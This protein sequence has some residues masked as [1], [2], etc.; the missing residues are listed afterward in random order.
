MHNLDISK[1]KFAQFVTGLQDLITNE[2]KKYDPELKITE[3]I[4]QRTDHLGLD[5]GGGR[6]RYHQGKI[7][8]A[9]GVNT[10]KVYGAIDPKFSQTLHGTG[11][12]LWATGISLIIHPINPRIPTVHANF[13][14]IHQGDKVWFGGGADLTPF[15]PYPE[16][17]E[18]FHSVWKNACSHYNDLG[19]N[20][21]EWMKKECDKYFVNQHR[22]QEMRGVSGI[23][24][25]HYYKHGI[26]QDGEKVMHLAN[27]FIK[28]YFPIVEKRYQEKWTDAD[29]EFQLHRRGRYV[30]FNLLHDRG[31]L[32][33]LKTKG[34]T[35][36]ILIS[37]PPRCKFTYNYA[38][39]VG[40]VHEK[41]MQ[42]YFVKN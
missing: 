4:W 5:G 15:Y 41:M 10:S 28:S 13:R 22:G 11:D 9:A 23:F 1:Q 26:D 39:P 25:D 19:E 24:F 27:H 38:P 3:D 12:S 8:E 35:E 16:D 31:T 34:R 14:M 36:S 33:G 6:T 21:Y 18:Y 32:F 40:S 20:D 17:F 37:L 2:M 29:E 7:F 30:E 42:Y